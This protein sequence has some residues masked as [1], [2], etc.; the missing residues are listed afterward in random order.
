MAL[1]G[2]GYLPAQTPHVHGQGVFLRPAKPGDFEQWASLR[3]RSRAFLVPWEPVWPEDDLTQSAFRRRIRRN[4]EE[5]ENEEAFAFLIFRDSDSLLVGGL[6][7][8]HIRR[9]VSQTATLGYWMGAP[10]AGN[11]LMSRAVRAALG[12]AFGRL[13]L[14][15]VEAACLPHNE[16]SMHLLQATGFEREGLARGYLRINGQWQDHVLFGQ[17][18]G[19]PPG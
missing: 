13:Q 1:F 15:R 16:A 19:A 2:L 5:I 4:L 3:A 8:G 18:G 9:G 7:L 10:Y 17:V 12:F 6:T 11:G 14:H